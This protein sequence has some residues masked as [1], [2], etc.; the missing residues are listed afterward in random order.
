LEYQGS[1]AVVITASHNGPQYN[2]YKL[3]GA[4]GAQ[5]VSPVD[6]DIA[7]RIEA[8]PLAKDI[9]YVAGALDGSHALA[10]PVEAA[11]VDRYFADVGALRPK[12]APVRDLPIVYTPLHG[13]GGAFVQRAFREAGFTKLAVVAEQFEPDG[14]FSTLRNPD[15]STGDPNPETGLALDLARKQGDEVGAQLLLANDPDA[16]RL[17]ANVRDDAGGWRQLTGNQIGVLLADYQLSRDEGRHEGNAALL[18][19]SIVST[20]MVESIARAYGARAEP[21]FTGFKWL[22]TAALALEQSEGLRRAA[23][24]TCGA[25]A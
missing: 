18:V 5:I 19:Y 20:P 13:V 12:D 6:E 14:N 11:L 21:T 4:N 10:R 22:W 25:G 17:A 3:Y 8:G 24:P 1:A 23:S 16:D 9:P 7:A 15:G 2:G